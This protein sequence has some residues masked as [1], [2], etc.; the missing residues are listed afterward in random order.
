MSHIRFDVF[1]G[2]R[3]RLLF[4]LRKS[5]RDTFFDLSTATEVRLETERVEI[6]KRTVLAAIIAN[7]SQPEADFANGRVVA[8]IDPADVTAI[9]GSYAFSLT[10]DI[11]DETITLAT[12]LIEVRDRPGFPV[13]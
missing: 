10:A 8:F 4:R 1:E 6:D 7:P 11:D 9:I 13:P 2:N 5:G 3:R 12:G